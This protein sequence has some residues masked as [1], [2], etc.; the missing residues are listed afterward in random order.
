MSVSLGAVKCENI[1]VVN[2]SF[3]Y[4]TSHLDYFRYRPLAQCRICTRINHDEGEGR[5]HVV[6][7]ALPDPW[8]SEGIEQT[9]LVDAIVRL[10]Q[11]APPDQTTRLRKIG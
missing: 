9:Y 4:L 1:Y 2:L 10:L 7:G 6:Q 8:G 5:E 3:Q 11:Q